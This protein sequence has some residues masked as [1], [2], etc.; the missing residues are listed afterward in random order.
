MDGYSGSGNN[1]LQHSH[2]TLYEAV[3]INGW[4]SKVSSDMGGENIEVARA[5]RGVNC[6]CS[7]KIHTSSKFSSK[8][9]SY[10]VNLIS[11]QSIYRYIAIHSV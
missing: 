4:P 10:S 7:N 5:A 8:K 9:Y 1:I 11:I 6:S 2:E 3:Q